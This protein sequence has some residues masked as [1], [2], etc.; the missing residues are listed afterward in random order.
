[1]V[2]ARMRYISQAVSEIRQID[3]HS[4]INTRLVKR[5]VNQGVIPAIR[6]GNG[7]RRLINL[8]M[9]LSYLENPPI[10]EHEAIQGI[11]RINP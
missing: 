7:N 8:D 9:L 2:K 4:P 5:L 3:P 1:M 11:R 6:V 10:E